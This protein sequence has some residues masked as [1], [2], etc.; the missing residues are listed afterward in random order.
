MES[1]MAGMMGEKLVEKMDFLLAEKKVG[2]WVARKVVKLVL[3]KEQKKVDSM[4]ALTV[5]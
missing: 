2:H 1:Q 4:A 5:E 3:M